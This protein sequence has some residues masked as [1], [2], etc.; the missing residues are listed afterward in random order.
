MR[1]ERKIGGGRCDVPAVQRASVVILCLPL[2]HYH[3]FYPFYGSI[4]CPQQLTRK[5]DRI[6][7]LYGRHLAG[8]R[9]QWLPQ[10]QSAISWWTRQSSIS[11]V[12]KIPQASRRYFLPSTDLSP[13]LYL[14]PPC[15]V[16]EP[17]G[18]NRFRTCWMEPRHLLLRVR[19]HM[20]TKPTLQR[21][22]YHD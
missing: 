8:K 11:T 13:A 15:G 9:Y 3:C 12:I 20:V 19:N 5:G 6:S 17:S 21:F 7:L 4:A 22:R 16:F 2:L 18:Q 1:I 10:L 14:Y